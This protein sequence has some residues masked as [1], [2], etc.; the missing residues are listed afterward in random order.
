M[1][2]DHCTSYTYPALSNTSRCG[3]P[4]YYINNKARARK[5]GPQPD[6]WSRALQPGAECAAACLGYPGRPT[7]LYE[8]YFEVYIYSIYYGKSMYLKRRTAIVTT[9]AVDSGCHYQILRET[10]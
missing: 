3:A 4:L 10:Y 2:L 9:T 1:F 6:T 7:N 5:S 8:V